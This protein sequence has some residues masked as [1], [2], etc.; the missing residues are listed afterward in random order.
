[1][2]FY[3]LV[4]KLMCR[5]FFVDHKVERM[6]LRAYPEADE[7]EIVWRHVTSR[8]EAR[9]KKFVWDEW[10]FVG[11]VSQLV[12]MRTAMFWP[13]AQ[14]FVVRNRLWRNRWRRRRRW[15]TVTAAGH[16][17]RFTS[18]VYLIL[19]WCYCAVSCDVEGQSASQRNRSVD[20]L[21]VSNERFPLFCVHL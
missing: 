19:P 10:I 21:P 6:R 16:L 4:F 11:L 2:N 12:Y 3:L 14:R 1:M 15:I 17:L 20:T 13:D 18:R 7:I 8:V 5:H 9:V